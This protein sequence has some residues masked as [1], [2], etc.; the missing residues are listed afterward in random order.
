MQ[1]RA[2]LHWNVTNYIVKNML[3]R[4]KDKHYHMRKMFSPICLIV[5]QYAT[6]D[7][8]TPTFANNVVPL[9]TVCWINLDARIDDLP[10]NLQTADLA[11]SQRFLR[12]ARGRE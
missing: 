8:T 5:S 12:L 11:P 7:I 4:K 10:G 2:Q 3:L 9:P 6:H 1:R